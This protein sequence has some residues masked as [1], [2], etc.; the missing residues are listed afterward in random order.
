[1]SVFVVKGWCPDA[2]HPMAAGDGLLV[3]VR[4]WLARLTREEV[5]SLCEAALLYGSGVIDLTSRGNVQLRGVRES[6]MLPLLARLVEL[7]LV[8]SDPA[9]ERRRNV[10]VA[11]D[12]EEG[13]DTARIARELVERL[14][15]LPDLPGKVGFV[16]DAGDGLA[17][18]REG[19]DFRV[20][21][22]RHGGLILR[23]AG[24][25][26]GAALNHGTEVD[27][28]IA[29]AHWFVETDGVRA[30]RME[31]HSATLPG[32]AQG[33]LA[34]TAV[35]KPSKAGRHRLGMALGVPFGRIEAK[36][37]ARLVASRS[38]EALR[39]TPWRLVLV[40]GH[41][42]CEGFVSNPDDSLLRVDAC[43]G[44]PLCR[45]AT[46]ETRELARR[47]A[48][49]IDGRLHVS[50]CAK[51]CARA[52]AADVTLTG[53]EGRFDLAADACAGA[54]PVLSGLTAADVVAH[55]GAA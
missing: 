9:C 1:M 35:A 50:G 13:D 42:D 5:V 17:L 27:A 47:I 43:P 2:W 33:D 40:E 11:P 19:G 54:P 3:R 10:L 15:E 37:L 8:V 29:L 18:C 53:R 4:P 16:I 36:T 39:I 30:G 24:R 52:A 26:C 55:F 49:Q 41:G 51:G 7:G 23:A 46:V 6:T 12:W 22:G 25:R 45:Q 32:F 20:E 48:P 28:L 14:H 38:V 44:R 34:P 21:R 31:R